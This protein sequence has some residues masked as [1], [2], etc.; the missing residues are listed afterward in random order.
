[1]TRLQI[2]LAFLTTLL[3]STPALAV[4]SPELGRFRTRDPV[5]YVDGSNLYAYTRGNPLRASDPMGLWKL[6]FSD[7]IG[8]NDRKT[9]Q[10]AVDKACSQVRKA[11]KLIEEASPCVHEYL[12]KKHGESWTRTADKLFMFQAECDAK[13]TV[14][15]VHVQPWV[16]EGD[17]APTRFPPRAWTTPPRFEGE[18]RDRFHLFLN[19]DLDGIGPKQPGDPGNTWH[20]NSGKLLLHELL[21]VIEFIIYHEDQDDKRTLDDNYELDKLNKGVDGSPLAKAIREAQR[22]CEE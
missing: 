1:M 13:T 7:N 3:V 5:R 2:L 18:A 16:P 12:L 8:P 10:D 14:V 9:I 15:N 19:N 22:C 17:E 11:N 21:H 6:E 4:Y 20:D